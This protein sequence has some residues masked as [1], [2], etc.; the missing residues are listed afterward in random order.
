MVENQP[1][2]QPSVTVMVIRLGYEKKYING[3]WLICIINLVPYRYGWKFLRDSTIAS[4]S[5]SVTK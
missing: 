3:P 2:S 4:I 5:L 1:I